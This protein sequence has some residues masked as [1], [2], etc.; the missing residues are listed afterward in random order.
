MSQKDYYNRGGMWLFAVGFIVTLAFFAYVMMINPGPIDTGVFNVPVIFSKAQSDERVTGWKQ[1]TPE[2]ITLGQQLYNVNCSSCHSQGGA[3]EVK[4]RFAAGQ[5]K[6]GSAPLQVYSVIRKGFKGEH[7]FD[8]L[9]EETKWA[10]TTFLRSQQAGAPEDS[11]ADW[12][13][14]LKDGLY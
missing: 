8:F 13:K 3:D 10:M 6:F 2:N 7:R 14:F 1:L 9:P 11:A 5:T 4:A 12:K